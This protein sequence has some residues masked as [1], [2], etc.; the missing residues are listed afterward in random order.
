MTLLRWDEIEPGSELP[1][2][3]CGP[4]SRWV[5]AMFAG[6]SGDHIAL[7]VDIDFA[8]KFGMKD[9]F[10]HGMLSM[11]YLA[12][13]LL[14]FAR[15]ENIRQYSVRFTAI[16][17]VHAKVRCFGKVV[18]KFEQAGEKRARLAIQTKIDDDS[19]TLDGEAV[20]AFP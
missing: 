17:P 11:A 9:V 14:R 1:V 3:E 18:E 10:A 6:G 5:L 15:Q 7:H 13:L 4:I 20:I 8:K 16:T 19:V 2:H 12:Q